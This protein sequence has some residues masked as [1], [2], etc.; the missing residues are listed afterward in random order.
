MIWLAGLSVQAPDLEHIL[1]L[2]QRQNGLCC[3]PSHYKGHVMLS[4]S[5]RNLESV[6]ATFGCMAVPH[7]PGALKKNGSFG[8]DIALNAVSMAFH[9]TLL[10]YRYHRSGCVC[11][12]LRCCTVSYENTLLI[13]LSSGAFWSLL[14]TPPSQFWYL[15][16]ISYRFN[17]CLSFKAP[18]WLPWRLP[19]L[20][21]KSWIDN[22]LR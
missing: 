15:F 20:Y 3:S 16:L 13:F 2:H 17:F 18:F 4:G 21:G 1:Y 11:G 9:S 22:W 5:L 19:N 14:S 10:M 12:N 6:D 8:R 7:L